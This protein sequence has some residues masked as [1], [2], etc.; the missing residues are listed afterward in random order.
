MLNRI[1]LVEDSLRLSG[2]LCDSLRGAGYQVTAF[3]RAADFKRSVSQ[4]K[5][6]LYVIDL[7]LPD[8]DGVDLIERRRAEGDNTPILVITARAS[9]DD[10]VAGLDC[11]ADDYL[12]KPFEQSIL[13]ARVRALLRRPQPDNAGSTRVGKLVV[14]LDDEQVLLDGQALVIRPTERRLL[15]VM[16][17]RI[18][19][20]VA[21]ESLEAALYDD[22]KDVSPNAVEQAVSRLRHVLKSIDSRLQI[23]TVWGTGYVL[24]ELG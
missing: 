24:E 9:V 4:T 17:R 8:G 1:L 3:G 5:S 15:S 16:A 13:L 6:S 19:K 11:G 14:N 7:G 21:R 10:H 20:L 23:R 2:L 18:G 22:G 12:V